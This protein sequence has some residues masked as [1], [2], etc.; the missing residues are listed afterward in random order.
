M[1]KYLFI[2]LLILPIVAC[3]QQDDKYNYNPETLETVKFIAL[4]SNKGFSGALELFPCKQGTTNYIG[5][6]ITPTTV[7]VINPSCLLT[8]GRIT[9]WGYKL[10][11]PLG[12][13]NILYWGISRSSAYSQSRV[14]APGLTAGVDLS[15]LYW[16]LVQNSDKRTYMP[17]WDQVMV[18]QSIQ[19]GGASVDDVNLERKVAGLNVIIKNTSGNAFDTSITAFEVLV[20]GIAEKINFATG[21]PENLTKTVK[22]TLSIDENRLMASNLTA[23][24][25]PSAASP[26][27]TINVKL[28]N[29]QTKSYTTNLTNAFEANTAQTITILT[30]D[31][32]S[33]DPS[34]TFSVES[35]KESSQ[36]IT[37]PNI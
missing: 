36:T 4:Q 25:Y 18:A 17:V 12:N 6:Y 2:A 13:Y 11:L 21:I 35:W 31:I 5:N 30:A 15:S 14:R 7:S 28:A 20:A 19:I 26:A 23:M 32:L 24:L 22:F 1:K 37:I 8:D 27:I 33:T 29:G 10:L 16:S 3:K 9:N 34:S